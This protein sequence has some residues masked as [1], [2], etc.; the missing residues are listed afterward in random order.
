MIP[1]TNYDFQGSREQWARDQIYPGNMAGWN[2]TH[3]CRW[4]TKTADKHYAF[5]CR[6]H[7]SDSVTGNEQKS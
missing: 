1:L 7:L 3:G 6:V 2:T 5:P 4:S